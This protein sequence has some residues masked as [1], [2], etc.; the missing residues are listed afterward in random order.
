[1]FT[2]AKGDRSDAPNV[3]FIVT[4]ANANVAIETTAATAAF[5]RRQYTY[6]MVLSVGLDPNVYGLRTLA[7]APYNQSVYMVDSFRDLTS[8]LNTGFVNFFIGRYARCSTVIQAVRIG[9]LGGVWLACRT[10]DREVPGST[11][12]QCTVRQQL[13]ASC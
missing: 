10:R 2:P 11:P 5:V 3:A 1:M 9:W 13:W 4:D 8:L 7:S 12:G 6:V